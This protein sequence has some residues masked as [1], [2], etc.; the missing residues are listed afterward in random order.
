MSSPLWQHGICD[1]ILYTLQVWVHNYDKGK[2]SATGKY[3]TKPGERGPN[4]QQIDVP[5]RRALKMPWRE[6]ELKY[7]VEVLE[8]EIPKSH[9]TYALVRDL[10]AN[11]PRWRNGKLQAGGAR[12]IE[13]DWYLAHVIQVYRLFEGL[14]TGKLHAQKPDL[15]AVDLEQIANG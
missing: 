2:V 11:L 1:N 12:I 4:M 15:G 9:E 5:T 14:K 6:V 3:L 10:K 13:I 8:K 7:F